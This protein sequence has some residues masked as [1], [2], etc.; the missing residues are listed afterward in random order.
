MKAKITIGVS[1][2]GKTTYAGMQSNFTTISRDDI[3]FGMVS[4]QA[5]GWKDY[6]FANESKVTAIQHIEIAKAHMNGENIIIADTNL[7]S[8]IR[9]NMTKCLKD[10]GYEVEWVIF[11]IDKEQAVERD[12]HRRNMTVGEEVIERQYQQYLS[13]LPYIEKQAR[14]LGVEFTEIHN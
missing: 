6:D 13:L 9:R 8:K 14:D 5:K 7:T 4:P 1:A 10:L 11:H 2:S 3:R 12:S